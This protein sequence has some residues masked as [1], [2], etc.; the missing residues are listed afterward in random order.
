MPYWR[1]DDTSSAITPSQRRWIRQTV[2]KEEAASRE[3]NWFHLPQIIL[4]AILYIQALLR[5]LINPEYRSTP[6]YNN[7]TMF[8]NHLGNYAIL[9]QAPA[10]WMVASH[11][12]MAIVWVLGTL[13]QKLLVW[14]MAKGERHALYCAR[15]HAILGTVMCILSI[16]GCSVGG[17]MAY[18]HHGH[19]PMRW[20]LMLLS[21]AFIPSIIMAWISAKKRDIIN[22][23]FWVTSAF[24][25]PC[26]SS[27]WAWEFIYLFGRQTSLGPWNGELL[28]TGL[29]SALHLLT[30]VVPAWLV[31][32]RQMASCDQNRATSAPQEVK[33]E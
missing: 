18:R 12:L 28:G 14:K 24:V 17:L 26:L 11:M 29:A 4:L 7:H 9:K 3:G 33:S 23:R 6:L 20:F 22:H 27:L 31:R 13:T 15:V 21:T 19:S 2:L 10:T 8:E 32:N 1:S 25:G 30:I 16:L 5:L